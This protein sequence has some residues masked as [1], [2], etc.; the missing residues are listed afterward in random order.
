MRI[1]HVVANNFRCAYSIT[2]ATLI[3]AATDLA[4]FWLWSQ[5]WQ[6]LICNIITPLTLLGI[7]LMGVKYYGNVEGVAGALKV[8]LLGCACILMFFINA[9]GKS[10]FTLS[11]TL[12]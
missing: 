10:S 2:F 5:A 12:D 9:G 11:D 6:I 1:F 7:N 8:L 3:S 4:A